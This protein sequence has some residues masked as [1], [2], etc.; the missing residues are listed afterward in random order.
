MTT[1]KS[2]VVTVNQSP[3]EV[4]TFLRNLNNLEKL[5]PEDRVKD[6]NSDENQCSFQIKG[7]AKIGMT[8]NS[9]VANEHLKFVSSSDKPFPFTLNI[10]MKENG[11]KSDCSIVFEGEMNAMLSM[12]AKTPLTNF[13]NMLADKLKEINE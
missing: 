2:K 10:F 4:F 13:F 12:M 8:Y 9:E 7:L 1:I 6:W 11:D 3:E 5:M